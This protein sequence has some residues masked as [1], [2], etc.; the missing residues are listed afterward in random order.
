M[1]FSLSV[2]LHVQVCVRS[3]RKENTSET[4]KR[5]LAVFIKWAQSQGLVCLLLCSIFWSSF[6][7]QECLWKS[8]GRFPGPH[9][10]VSW[11]PQG[12][13]GGW[14]EAGPYRADEEVLDYS[15]PQ[16]QTTAFLLRHSQYALA[17]I[18]NMSLKITDFCLLTFFVLDSNRQCQHRSVWTTAHPLAGRSTDQ[19][20]CHWAPRDG[21]ATV[22]E[23]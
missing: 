1:F 7:S 22:L 3:L 20:D 21:R 15:Q 10:V 23:G 13:F 19:T 9:G 2:V 12:A 4:I 5:K 18:F 14:G 8:G 16:F 17:D 11:T 6:G